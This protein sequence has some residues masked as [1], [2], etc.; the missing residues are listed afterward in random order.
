MGEASGQSWLIRL[1]RTSWA[2]I[3]G[4][5]LFVIVAIVVGALSGILVPFVVA[6]LIGILLEPLTV[7]LEHRGVRPALS[8]VLTLGLAVL[9]SVAILW[10]LLRGLIQQ[11]PEIARQLA[12][13]WDALARWVRQLDIDP[14]VVEQAQTAVRTY[15]P[16]TGQGLLGLVSST[17]LGAVSLAFGLFFSL[18]FLF[19]VLRDGRRF[20][21]W[22]ASVTRRDAVLIEETVLLSKRSL[23]GYF[24]GIALTAVITAPIFA[25]PLLLLGIPLVL[26]VL[27]LYFVLSFIPYV[28]AWL[29]GAFAILIASGAGGPV[30]A[31]I[32]GACR[33][34]SNGAIQSMVSSWALGAS[35][36]M[37][38]VLVLFATIVVGTVAGILGMILGPPVLAAVQASFGSMRRSCAP[39][40]VPP[41]S[42]LR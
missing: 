31:L 6:V 27:I 36:R 13:G 42:P 24:R 22:L 16:Q 33:L 10:V 8:A 32:V 23:R 34:I 3:G 7:W 5:A 18:F 38:P 37:H 28:G 4:I 35:L 12:A 41:A 14:A 25:I 2:A 19:F 26:P 29:T 40:P 17:L 1:G 15:A 30:P 9:T 21:A 39:E 11:G 20:P